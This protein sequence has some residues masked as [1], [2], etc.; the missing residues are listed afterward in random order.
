MSEG[1][2][3]HVQ[4]ELTEDEYEAFREFAR[5]HG[6]GV[7]EFETTPPDEYAA[8]QDLVLTTFHMEHDPAL[9]A[10]VSEL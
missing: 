1:E 5:D 3:K 7:K 8:W 10:I 2:Y 6:L 9:P 4:T